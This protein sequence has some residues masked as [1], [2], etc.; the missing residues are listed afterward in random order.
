MGR[1]SGETLLAVAGYGCSLAL[2]ALSFWSPLSLVPS[3]VS[4]EAPSF[5]FLVHFGLVLSFAMLV[6]RL[7]IF[8]ILILL[9][10]ATWRRS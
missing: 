5:Y 7:E 6:G 10:P 8:P 2:S 1:V 9:N 4:Q 3:A